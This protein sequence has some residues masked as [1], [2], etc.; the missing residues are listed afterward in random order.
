MTKFSAL[1]YFYRRRL[2]TSN[3]ILQTLLY[4]EQRFI[5]SVMVCVLKHRMT[6][7]MQLN[8]VYCSTEF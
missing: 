3:G 2:K 5:S 4:L 6:H 1:F 7:A 8:S